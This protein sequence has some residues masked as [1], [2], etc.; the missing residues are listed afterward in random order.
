MKTVVKQAVTV[1]GKLGPTKDR[2]D[3]I[4]YL[5]KRQ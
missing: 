4:K 1:I 3:F 5:W 2:K